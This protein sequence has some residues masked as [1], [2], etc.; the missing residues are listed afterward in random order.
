MKKSFLMTFFALAIGMSLH[1]VR[2]VHKLFPQ[3]QSN[4]TTVMLYTNGDG[5][6]AFYTTADDQVVVRDSNGTLCYAELKDGVLVPTSV[7]VHN[8]DE[9]SVEEKAFVLSNK[10]KPTDDALLPLLAPVNRFQETRRSIL[11]STSASTSD[12]LGKYGT[13]AIGPL[14]SIG[15]MKIPV[16]LVEFSDVKFQDEHNIE[17]YTRFMNEEGYHEDSNYQ[18]GSVRDYFLSQSRGMFNPTFDVV[19][20]VTLDNTC[21]YYGADNSYTTDPNVRSMLK[22]AITKAISQGV[23]FDAYETKYRINNII[24]IYAGY[25]QAT[26]GDDN[27]LWPHAAE[28]GNYYGQIGDYIFGSYFVGNE[29]YGGSGTQLMGMGVM[30]HELGHVLGLP[31]FYETK[32]TYQHSDN[33]MGYWSVMDGGEYYP[34]ST[35]YA[36]VGYNAYE[37]SYMGWLDL[38]ELKDAEAIKLAPQ[39]SDDGEFAVLLRNPSDEK[40]YFILENRAAGTW[41]PEDLGTGLLVSRFAYNASSWEKNTV[42]SVQKYKRAMVITASGRL[43][44]GSGE[45]TDLFGNSVNNI[46]SLT[47]FNTST[48][49]A[50]IY[51]IMK[52]P[53]GTLTFNYKDKDLDNYYVVSNDEKYVKVE[54]AMSLKKDDEIIFVDEKDKLAM[55]TSLY[56]N[57]FMPVTVDVSNGI[58]K[59]NDLIQTFTLRP[60]G[61]NWLILSG[62]KYLTAVSGGLKLGTTMTAASIATISVLDGSSSVVFGG[63]VTRKNLGFDADNFYF[64]TFADTQSNLQI[65]RKTGTTG[66]STVNAGVEKQTDGRM[67]NLSGQQVGDGYKGIVIVDGKKVVRK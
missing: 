58:A 50:H 44:T 53:D 21:A 51:K 17:K 63:N 29:L 37:R 32:Y 26:G 23:N 7:V 62:K 14:P 35:A 64:T 8:I 20:K 33:P 10:L 45:P 65:Y 28:L 30:V 22:D 36:P 18:K 12:G 52:S 43:M 39:T 31:D 49:D 11:K 16:L 25:G 2:A 54:D 41:Y 4:G 46:N 34:Q 56:D 67:Y 3:R 57:A 66:I 60:N 19:A 5:R 42:N 1:A 24:I 59:G 9:R 15:T 47:L 13:S 61:P 40:E 48:L 27:T 6:L 55:T 38:R